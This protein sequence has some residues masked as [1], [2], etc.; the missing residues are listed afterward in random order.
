M[1]SFEYYSPTEIVFG[2]GAE[3][4]TAEKIKKN[5]GTKVVLVYGGG[6]VV[7]SGLLA[8]LENELDAAEIAFAV[9]GGVQP[10]PRMA[11]AREGVKAAAKFGADMILAVGGGSVRNFSDFGWISYPGICRLLFCHDSG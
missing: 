7:R 10:N 3:A 8:R 1:Q 11:H 2:R 6:S 4:K 9:F 5:G